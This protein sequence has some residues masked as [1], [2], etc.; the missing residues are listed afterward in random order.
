MST[1]MAPAAQQYY[2]GA[3]GGRKAQGA[4]RGMTARDQSKTK[5]KLKKG[6]EG[7]VVEEESIEIMPLALAKTI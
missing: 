7:V 1:S 5:K 6:K 4:A 3:R 2:T